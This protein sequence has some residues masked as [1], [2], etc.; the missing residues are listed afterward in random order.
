MDFD[1]TRN[2]WGVIYC[3]KCMLA[4]DDWRKTEAK[5]TRPECYASLREWLWRRK[6]WRKD[7]IPLYT[8][9]Q[10]SLQVHCPEQVAFAKANRNKPISKGTPLVQPAS[11]MYMYYNQIQTHTHAQ[12]YH[13]H[14]ITG[15]ATAPQKILFNTSEKSFSTSKKFIELLSKFFCAPIKI[16]QCTR[17]TLPPQKNYSSPQKNSS[18]PQKNFSAPQK[19]P[20]N[21]TK[22]FSAPQKNFQCPRKIL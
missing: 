3:R 22:A 20:S 11:Y 16:P 19:N 21:T 6:R 8:L 7:D 13:S 15:L 1:G 4:Q 17:K 18:S 5:M 12:V 2:K 14:L 10:A 9:H